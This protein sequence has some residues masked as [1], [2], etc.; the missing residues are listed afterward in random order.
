MDVEQR[1][2]PAMLASDLERDGALLQLHTAFAEGRL[3]AAELDERMD[4]V[5]AARTLP[6][7]DL[8]VADLPARRDPASPPD[9]G[10]RA[11]VATEP[12]RTDGRWQLAYKSRVRRAGRWRVPRR[13][14]AVIYKG[15]S[16][17][18]LSAAD[19][20]APV[21]TLRALAY[22]SRIEIVA[23]PGVRV[24]LGGLGVSGAVDGDPAPDA[25]VL[26]V[27]GLAYKGIVEVR[28]APA[29]E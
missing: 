3:T 5:L 2:P 21:T 8:L 14:T 25:P 28:S 12:A 9:P 6:D 20:D 13:Y 15:G 17:L 16:L 7:L 4:A 27:R 11:A 29:P 23:P 19:L 1:K 24:E 22:K 10:A 18:D 26:R